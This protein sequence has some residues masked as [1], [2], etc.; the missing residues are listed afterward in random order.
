MW[1]DAQNN[2]QKDVHQ[3]MFMYVLPYPFVFLI[4]TKVKKKMFC[5]GFPIQFLDVCWMEP[6]LLYVHRSKL[7]HLGSRVNAHK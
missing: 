7:V 3:S 5:Q 4:W 1:G 2:L 6:K